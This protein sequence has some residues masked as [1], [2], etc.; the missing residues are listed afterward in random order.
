MKFLPL[1]LIPLLVTACEK[2]SIAEQWAN[3]DKTFSKLDQPDVPT[4][5]STL[6]RQAEE[7]LQ[8]N[9]YK[10]AA[11]FYQQMI[12]SKKTPAKDKLRYRAIMADMLRR[13]GE[14][15]K[16]LR[17]FN[18][19]LEEDP[20]HID[21]LEGKGL[22]EMA[23]GQSADA[24]RTLSKVLDKDGKRWRTLNALG[25]L[26]VTKNMIPEAVEYFT[27]GLRVSRD[28]PAILNNVGLARAID[29]NY[30]R[31]IETLQQAAKMSV[32]EERKK[33]VELNLALVYGISGDIDS[34]RAMA[35]KHLEGATLDNNLGLYA[36]LAKN[37]EL[38]KT[39]LNMALSNSPTYYERAWNNLDIITEQSNPDTKA[40]P[41]G[42]PK[43][44]PIR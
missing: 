2:G 18:E 29:R 34:A 31:A 39:Y 21:A 4:V 25:I 11:G 7:A 27:E 41:Y 43:S 35:E 10:R 9:D 3:P 44:V 42:K 5:Q 15:E 26:F 12:D 37:D 38:A 33:Q 24:G 8:K 6:E 19:V 23:L 32:T 22:T 14:N 20:N 40:N 28:N 30:P 1:I 13:I 36:H 17:Q 16:A